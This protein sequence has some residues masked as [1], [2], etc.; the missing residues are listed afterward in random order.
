MAEFV[1]SYAGDANELGAAVM[2]GTGRLL[3]TTGAGAA[4]IVL[5]PILAFIMILNGPGFRLRFMA[6]IEPF[7]HAAMWRH[8]VDDLDTLLG[9]YIRALLILAFATI[10]SYTVAFSVAGV[11][12]GLLLA[13]IAGALEFI[14]VLGPLA[15]AVLCVLVAGISGYDHLLWI[16]GFIALYR[17]F[18]DYVLNPYLMSNGVAV[19]ALLVLFGLLA[20]E[21]LAGVAGVFLS[22]P[23]LAAM[24]IFARRIAEESQSN[25]AAR[26]AA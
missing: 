9:G 1:G 7:A 3:V 20:G 13:L 6:W 25:R 14:P 15:A 8:I 5:L 10:V 24:Q 21:E 11:P 4:F 18:Q 17:I 12:Y 22:T 19:P 16:V 2:K 26:Q 23:V